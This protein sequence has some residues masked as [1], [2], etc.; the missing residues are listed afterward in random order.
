[1]KVKALIQFSSTDH[2]NVS[3]GQVIEVGNGVAYEM[4]NAG[5]VEI[6]PEKKPVKKE[7]KPLQSSQAGQASQQTKPKKSEA[8]ENK[9]ESKS[10][11][12]TRATKRQSATTSTQQTGDGGKSTQKRRGRKPKDTGKTPTP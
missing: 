5:M 11:G 3:E 1:M 2:G 6:L 4:R 8:L 9:G 12:S 10:L 7:T